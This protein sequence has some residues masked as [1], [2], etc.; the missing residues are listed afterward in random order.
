MPQRTSAAVSSSH[1]SAKFSP[2]NIR[3]V[4]YHA[5]VKKTAEEM[6]A[7][8]KQAEEKAK[9]KACC[10]TGRVEHCFS[11]S[12]RTSSPLLLPR[13]AH[14][15]RALSTAGGIARC[16]NGGSDDVLCVG[17]VVGEMQAERKA[18]QEA[19]VAR[20]KEEAAKKEAEREAR[21]LSSRLASAAGRFAPFLCDFLCPSSLVAASRAPTGEERS[22]AHRPRGGWRRRGRHRGGGRGGG[23]RV[24][25]APR[26]QPAPTR[27]DSVLRGMPGAAI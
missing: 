21:P 8:Q 5:F 19:N 18:Q 11:S 15:P 6:A 14:S 9:L 24:N 17:P 4:L 27:R 10:G 23:R 2:F 13:R 16:A 25:A 1:Y 7:L 12:T 26:D 3:Q 22:E 20:K